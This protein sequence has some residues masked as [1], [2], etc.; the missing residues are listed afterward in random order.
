[1]IIKVCG[2]TCL[3]DALEALNCGAN[4]LGF[5]FHPPSPR[6]V[7][8]ST[9]ERI[10]SRLSTEVLTVAVYVHPHKPDGFPC[11]ALQIHGA[12]G[13][14]D[15]PTGRRTFVAVD[16]DGIDRFPDSEIIIDPSWG[17]GRQA[18][19]RRLQ[20]VSRPY[21]LSGGLTPE[22]VGYAVR[23]LAPYGVDVCSGVESSPGFKDHQKMKEFM[24]EVFRATSRP[25]STG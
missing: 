16:V 17:T 13:E 2:I 6:C 5:N 25:D 4:A 1:V 20:A 3:E 15:L 21:V 24:E 7:S 22:N 19:W 11:S 23:L 10:I 12:A 9:A 8:L 18:D 14:A